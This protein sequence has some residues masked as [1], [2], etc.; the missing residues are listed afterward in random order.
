MPFFN[1]G[2]YWFIEGVFFCLAVIG[3][4][5]WMEDR[6]ISM[7]FWKWGILGSWIFLFAFTIAFVGTS[8]GEKEPKA[9]LLG[10]IIF[11][12]VTIIT[13]VGLWR[14]LFKRK[15]ARGSSTDPS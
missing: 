5:I 1:S 2:L 8:L 4:K 10:G 15:K 13:G 3:F 14:L 11:G 12:L 9:A 7:P 6:G